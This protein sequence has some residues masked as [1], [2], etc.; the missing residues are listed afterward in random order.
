MPQHTRPSPR[1][2]PER[3]ETRE[4]FSAGLDPT[5]GA[6]G[7]LDDPGYYGPGVADPHTD[8]F[9]GAGGQIRV[10]SIDT[11]FTDSV[12]VVPIDP[13]GTSKSAV[14]RAYFADESLADFTVL[15]DGRFLTGS[16]K[17]G[18][19]TVRRFKSGGTLDTTF[20]NQG[21][22]ILDTPAQAFAD[23]V[24]H[25]VA[26][27]DGDV[28]VYAT[29][30]ET[31]YGLVRLNPDG[32]LDTGFSG[33]GKLTLPAETFPYFQ[34][35]VV[36]P[37]GKLVGVGAITLDG[38]MH[39]AIYRFN[40]GGSLDTT[41]GTGGKSVIASQ[42]YG[43]ELAFGPGGG[44]VVLTNVGGRDGLTW[45]DGAGAPLRTASLPAGVRAVDA[46]VAVGADG[47]AVVSATRWDSF[48]DTTLVVARYTAAGQPDATF[49]PN[50]TLTLTPTTGQI[51]SRD[52]TTLSDG[53]VLLLGNHGRTSFL[54][55]LSD[56]APAGS[57]PTYVDWQPVQQ[58]E[59]AGPGR[60]LEVPILPVVG[61]LGTPT[62]TATAALYSGGTL[63]K[64]LGTAT[65]DSNGV[66]RF[67]ADLPEGVFQLRVQYS[68]DAVHAP[69]THTGWVY[70]QRLAT[71]TTLSASATALQFGRSVTLTA[72][73]A[74]SPYGPD[75]EQPTTGTVTFKDGTTVLGTVPLAADGTATL[76]LSSMRLGYRQITATYSGDAGN[77]SSS[78]KPLTITVSPAV[79]RVSVTSSA[80]PSAVG[81]WVTFRATVRTDTGVPA[82]GMVT[83][84]A[85]GTPIGV[86]PVNGAGVATVLY[87]LPAGQHGITAEYSGSSTVKSSVSPALTQQVGAATPA[88]T[89]TALTSAVASPVYGQPV[90]LTATVTATGGGTP[91]GRV[92]FLD[93][94]TVLGSAD[95]GAGGKAVLTAKLNPGYRQLRAVYHGADGFLG[96]T[97]AALKLTVGKAATRVTVA[98]PTDP[99]PLH[100][101]P[102]VVTVRPAY[103]GSPIGT[104]T[105]KLGDTVLRT[106]QLNGNGQASVTLDGM[107]AG[108]QTIRVEYGGSSTFLG[109][110]AE[111]TLDV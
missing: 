55:R 105:I 10:G 61:G 2:Q 25:I 108:R 11:M 86:A 96:S 12:E 14:I 63:P 101:I 9:V 50:G 58:V 82:V 22:V 21:L 52:V 16:T 24:E 97:S 67:T 71:T 51:F 35:L 111:L 107:V 66:A 7:I 59:Q 62:G 44:F 27:P 65:L 87:S 28:Y 103:Q 29:F 92:M 106:V 69:Q 47:R 15:P 46:D 77:K 56:S 95:V 3:L 80:N 31:A 38:S 34:D 20:G 17:G 13:N 89:Q 54:A 4:V 40:T 76:T 90:A 79:S 33:D 91:T 110:F 70:F 39:L 78:A 88:A 48:V 83:L 30:S 100:T 93:G 60:V 6:G 23:G 85:N 18:D 41:F 49:G 74:D 64:E 53:R 32:S 73:V 57:Q 94:T 72:R 109:S 19:V 99:I 8:L 37:D 102:L 98:V 104:V 81:Q 68:G 5:F 84:K 36:R 75:P 43:T 26:A 1:M 42:S 45:Y